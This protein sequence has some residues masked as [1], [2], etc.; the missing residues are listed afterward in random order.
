MKYQSKARLICL[1]ALFPNH[2]HQT[3]I[4]KLLGVVLLPSGWDGDIRVSN[5]GWHVLITSLTPKV[6]LDANILISR[7]TV[8]KQHVF[9]EYLQVSMDNKK[10][11]DKKERHL[12]EFEN[13][14]VLWDLPF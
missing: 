3:D 1:K 2:L 14:I 12:D 10:K 8:D 11:Q 6:M 7:Q 9:L 13:E 5:R 4:G